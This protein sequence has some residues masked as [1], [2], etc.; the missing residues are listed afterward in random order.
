MA[1]A[2]ASAPVPQK[3]AKSST[4]PGLAID[5][6]LSSNVVMA[7]DF[8][9][10]RSVATMSLTED[11]QGVVVTITDYE[12]AASSEAVYLWTDAEGAVL[13][14]GTTRHAVGKRLLEYGRHINRRLAGSKSPTPVWEAHRWL[15][16]ATAG[17]MIALVHVPDT[18]ATIAGP[19]R[20]YLDIERVL[21]HDLKPSLNRSHR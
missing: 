19:V 2:R 9:R 7:L 8:T 20:P 17:N 10:F 14:V 15:E 16:L 6:L 3:G 18:V 12:Q 11:K 13:R 1:C 4:T 21:I 5:P